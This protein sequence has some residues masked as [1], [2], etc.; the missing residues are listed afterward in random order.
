MFCRVRRALTHWLYTV[1]E[2]I[3]S[4]INIL[5]TMA[6]GH[7]VYERQAILSTSVVI[8]HIFCMENEKELTPRGAWQ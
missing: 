4:A 6:G 3:V 8:S 7:A 5:K 2:I 1:A